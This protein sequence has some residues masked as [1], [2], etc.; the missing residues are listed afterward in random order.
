MYAPGW[1]ARNVIWY[2]AIISVTPSF[3]GSYRFSMITLA[4]YILGVIAGEMFGG[5][6]SDI[7]LE[8]LHYGWLIWVAVYISSAIIGMLVEKKV[9]VKICRFLKMRQ[10]SG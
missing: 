5:F 10:R 6:K 2:A 9:V 8:Y 3:F 7:P 4:G 1:T